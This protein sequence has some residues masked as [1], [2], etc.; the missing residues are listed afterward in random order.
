MRRLDSFGLASS[1]TNCMC[2]TLKSR[3]GIGRREAKGIQTIQ[4]SRISEA[5]RMACSRTEY[6]SGGVGLQFRCGRF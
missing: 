4:T 6:R 2:L 5:L 1:R 3:I